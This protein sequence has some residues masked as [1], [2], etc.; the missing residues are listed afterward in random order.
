MAWYVA[1]PQVSTR[2][3]IT[4]LRIGGPAF[5][6]GP[7]AGTDGGI[8]KPGSNAVNCGKIQYA[9]CGVSPDILSTDFRHLQLLCHF[10]VM[11]DS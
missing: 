3:I 5:R 7:T 9:N 4:Y 8:M 1:D 2:I 11:N 6:G 10:E